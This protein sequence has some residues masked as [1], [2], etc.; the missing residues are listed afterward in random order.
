MAPKVGQASLEKYLILQEFFLIRS[1]IRETL[2]L[3]M[4]LDS[5]TNTEMYKNRK[6]GTP[7]VSSPPGS[8]VSAMAQA[9]TQATHGHGDLE[10]ESAQ[11]ANSVKSHNIRISV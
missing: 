3:L 4:C 6:K 9:H 11:W 7:E 8:G 10:T 2:N 5:S 1:R